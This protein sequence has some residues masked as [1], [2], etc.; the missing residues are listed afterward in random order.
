MPLYCRVGRRVVRHRER[1]LGRRRPPGLDPGHP[2]GLQLGD[3]L[4]GDFGVEARPVLAGTR[5]SS[6]VLTSR[7]SA[8]GAASL[9][10]DLQPVTAN[11]VRTLTLNRDAA[12][13]RRPAVALRQGW[14]PEG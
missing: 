6:S 7:F 8:T 1:R 14:K 11:P 9:S 12:V 3:D 2:A 10:R 13:G 5:S 4:V